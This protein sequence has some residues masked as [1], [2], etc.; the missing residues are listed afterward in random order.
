[1]LMPVMYE[2]SSLARKVAAQAMSAGV[3]A[4][5]IGTTEVA[6]AS[7]SAGVR[8]H[9]TIVDEARLDRVDAHAPR[10]QIHRRR[11]RERVDG[12]LHRI[13]GDR[14]AVR[15]NG[16]VGADVDD[17]ALALVGHDLGRAMRAVEQHPEV[18]RM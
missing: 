2:A 14:V 3:P 1:M 4:R 11:A 18:G 9:P 15:A 10:R 12:A 5:P 17:A 6:N 7:V 13:V 16:A 8:R